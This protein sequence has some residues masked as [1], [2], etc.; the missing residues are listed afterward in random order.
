MTPTDLP[1]RI[2]KRIVVDGA[3]GCWNWTAGTAGK[4]Y[5]YFYWEGGMAYVHRIVYHLVVD[6]ALPIRGGG[7]RVCIDHLCGNKVCA[8]P[9][10]LELVDWAENLRRFH[11]A[12]PGHNAKGWV[13]RRKQA[14]A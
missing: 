3:T 8:N 9:Q 10:H 12:N 13:T 2:A 14:A 7:R 1:A 11:D 6:D 4:G 5:G